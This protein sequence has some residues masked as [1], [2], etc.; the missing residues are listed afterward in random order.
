[1]APSSGTVRVS[2]TSEAVDVHL[3]NLHWAILQSYMRQDRSSTL[4]FYHLESELIREHSK[5]INFKAT[6][7]QT[8]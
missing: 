6:N 2:T 8:S 3:R 5:S 4:S 1:M 7:K